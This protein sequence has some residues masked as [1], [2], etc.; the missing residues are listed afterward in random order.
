VENLRIPC[1]PGPSLILNRSSCYHDSQRRIDDSWTHA[2]LRRF[3][4]AT[5]AHTHTVYGW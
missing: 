2:K 3:V 4:S 1:K 5:H